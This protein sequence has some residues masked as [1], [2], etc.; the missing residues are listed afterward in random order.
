MN[1]G[2]Q[3]TKNN[4]KLRKRKIREKNLYASVL[5]ELTECQWAEKKRQ[6]YSIFT[7]V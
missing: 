1:S 4:K 3:N 5:M 7:A 6:N 2:W